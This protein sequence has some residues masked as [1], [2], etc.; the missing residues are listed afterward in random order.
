MSTKTTAI[1]KASFGTC[2]Y[3]GQIK[4]MDPDITDKELADDMA[5]MDCTCIAGD[6]YRRFQKRKERIRRKIA[7]LFPELTEGI[8][9]D[10][11]VVEWIMRDAA[12]QIARGKLEKIVLVFPENV[13]AA[14]TKDSKGDVTIERTF[15]KKQ[16]L[17]EHDPD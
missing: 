5:T 8:D 14:I 1:G 12:E 16:K 6:S 7:L 15:T 17:S 13:K 3:C 10:K 2:R 4:I 9:E 11:T